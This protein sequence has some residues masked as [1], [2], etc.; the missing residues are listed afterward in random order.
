MTTLILFDS[1]KGA[2]KEIADK[3]A[4]KIKNGAMVLSIT[5][6]VP[7]KDFANYSNIVFGAS[8]YAGKLSK[9]ATDFLIDYTDLLTKKPLILFSLG[10][11]VEPTAIDKQ[12]QEVF[13]EEVRKHAKA[14]IFIGGKV[15]FSKLNF[16]ERI[17]IKK[18]LSDQGVKNL[19][20]NSIYDG[21]RQS[22]VD[23]LIAT[24]NTS[25]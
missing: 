8:V 12:L 1:K 23:E 3:I 7:P 20:K 6:V 18:I 10:L 9:K 4:L 21:I 17:I 2:S 22:A 5:D 14:N 11:Q 15:T 16:F 13:P 25:N 24:I 19:N